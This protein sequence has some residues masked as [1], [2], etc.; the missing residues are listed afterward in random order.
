[1]IYYDFVKGNGIVVRIFNIVKRIGGGQRGSAL[2][3]FSSRGI[4]VPL[5]LVVELELA[6]TT[7]EGGDTRNGRCEPS[8]EGLRRSDERMGGFIG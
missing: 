4:L 7:D 1:L 8:H 2:S 3:S 6:V 5:D